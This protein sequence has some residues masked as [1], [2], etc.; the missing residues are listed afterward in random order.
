MSFYRQTCSPAPWETRGEGGQTAREESGQVGERCRETGRTKRRRQTLGCKCCSLECGCSLAEISS[1]SLTVFQIQ[2]NLY[3]LHSSPFPSQCWPCLLFIRFVGSLG[4]NTWVAL[5][6]LHSVIGLEW[7]R[8]YSLPLYEMNRLW[9]FRLHVVLRVML[10]RG[11]CFLPFLKQSL[12]CPVMS[13]AFSSQ[14]QP[15]STEQYREANWETAAY[16]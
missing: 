4:R 9:D 12:R 7:R 16:W 1:R 10:H 13:A 5:L 8:L 15:I 11:R 14:Q 2:I 3:E 6:F